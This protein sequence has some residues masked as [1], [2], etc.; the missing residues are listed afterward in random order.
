MAGLL[1]A[2]LIAPAPMVAAAGPSEASA[3]AFLETIYRWYRK[4]SYGAPMKRP[5]RW[6]EPKLA[7]AI[8][9]D[10]A[11]ADRKGEIGKLEA[12]PFCDCQDFDA[13]AAV[14]GPVAITG[15]RASVEVGFADGIETRMRYTLV[16]TRGGWRVFDIRWEEGSLRELYFPAEPG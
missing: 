16:W 9:A 3:R 4:G 1:L 8:R 7:A 14:I 6:F 11:E 10:E 13:L 2:A 12:D 15:G 5:E